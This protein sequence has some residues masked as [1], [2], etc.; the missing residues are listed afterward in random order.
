MTFTK[1]SIDR[2][3]TKAEREAALIQVYRQVLERQPYEF[4]RRLLVKLE[5]DFLKGKLGVRHF[6][7]E[8][9]AS[10]VYLDNFYF[11]TSTP[12]FIEFCFKHFLG[13]AP[14]DHQEMQSY[15]I[16]FAQSGT[17][18]VISAILGSDEYAKA[19]GCFTIPHPR[20]MNV[21]H[22]PQNFIESG[23]LNHEHTCQRGTK[24]PTMFWRELGLNCDGG[25]CVHPEVDGKYRMKEELL[26]A[27]DA[28][29]IDD[30]MIEMVQALKREEEE[31]ARK[32]QELANRQS[33]IAK[34]RALSQGM[35]KR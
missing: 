32:K 18:G 14:V 3:S 19:F 23:I 35:T 22:S 6:I 10:S 20:Q 1:T 8:L 12:K 7:R 25:T 31:L 24:V 21:Y 30:K 26:E 2:K 9:A 28:N 13:R 33:E 34:R 5:K 17:N 11:N 16:I 29:L 27:L 15:A 4:E